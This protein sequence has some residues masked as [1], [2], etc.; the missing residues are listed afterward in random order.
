[1]KLPRIVIVFTIHEQLPGTKTGSFIAFGFPL[2]QNAEHFQL[3]G[4]HALVYR[5]PMQRLGGCRS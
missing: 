4:L 5:E 1:M 3:A 2:Q